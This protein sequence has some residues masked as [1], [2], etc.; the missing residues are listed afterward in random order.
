MEIKYNL[1]EDDYINFNMFHIRNS[2]SAMRSLK[3]QRFAVPIIYIILPF[4]FPNALDSTFIFTL[5]TFFIVSILWVVFYPKYFYKSVNRRLKKMI[6]EGKNEG[7]IG[8]HKLITTVEGITDTTS[9]GE[10]K[11]NWS[12]IKSLKEDSDY[13]YIYNS[14]VSAYILP[15]RDL[16]DVEQIR[17]YLNSRIPE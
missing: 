8:E 6:K 13:L 14:S 1:T 16:K 3:I 12:G 5:I 11:V 2:K 4:V 17:D 9:Y 7:L 10:T 15:K